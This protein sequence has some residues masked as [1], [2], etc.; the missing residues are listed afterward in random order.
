MDYDGGSGMGGESGAGPVNV[1]GVET[2]ASTAE[3]EAAILTEG[4]ELKRF[5]L[6]QSVAIKQS[7]FSHNAHQCHPASHIPTLALVIN[8]EPQ[9]LCAPQHWWVHVQHWW[10]HV[11]LR[12][13]NTFFL[14]GKGSVVCIPPLLLVHN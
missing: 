2:E 14:G 7:A 4:A 12:P 5:L 11:Q 8:A 9:N 3:G 1:V 13:R 6:K 10:M